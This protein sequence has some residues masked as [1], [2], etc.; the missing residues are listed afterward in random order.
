MVGGDH[1]HHVGV[2]A[3]QELAIVAVC[4]RLAPADLLVVLGGLHSLGVDGAYG[5][6]VAEGGV[7]AGV[8]ATFGAHADAADAQPVVGRRLGPREVV[9]EK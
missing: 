3:F 4:G 6:D 1:A 9:Q 8:A 2:L 5:H 7:L